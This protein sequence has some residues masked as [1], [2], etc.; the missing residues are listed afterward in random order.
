MSITID[1]VLTLHDTPQMSVVL[2]YF[3]LLSQPRQLDLTM[4][5]GVYLMSYKQYNVVIRLFQLNNFYVEIYSFD[6]DGKVA[7]I[8]A[9]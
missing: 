5:E 9:F 1:P 8:N 2:N 4:K 6:E 3:N 7:M